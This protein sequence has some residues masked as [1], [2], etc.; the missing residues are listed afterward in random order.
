MLTQEELLAF[1][2]PP[3]ESVQLSRT[4]V[5]RIFEEN[6]NYSPMEMDYKVWC[7]ASCTIQ[8]TCSAGDHPLQ[9]TINN[10]I[11]S[12]LS[13]LLKILKHLLSPLISFSDLP[14]PPP[15]LGVQSDCGEHVLFLADLRP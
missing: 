2:G 10:S 13:I 11:Q 9:P 8:P 6:I 14:R 15:S 4:A 12:I 3:N 7:V 5:R 1:T